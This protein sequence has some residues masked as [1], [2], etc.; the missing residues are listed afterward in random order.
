MGLLLTSST[1]VAANDQNNNLNENKSEHAN[2][3]ESAPQNPVL[4]PTQNP[5]TGEIIYL[6][7]PTY[8]DCPGIPPATSID[9]Y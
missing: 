8:P 2:N 3:S 7:C 1:Y 9:N 6:L 4:V 5:K